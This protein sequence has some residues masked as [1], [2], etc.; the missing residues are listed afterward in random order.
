[1][2]YLLVVSICIAASLWG[3]AVAPIETT[4]KLPLPP[5]GPSTQKTVTIGLIIDNRFPFWPRNEASPPMLEQDADK[6]LIKDFEPRPVTKEIRLPVGEVRSFLADRLKKSKRFSGVINPPL[7]IMGKKISTMLKNCLETSDYLIVGEINAFYTKN[8][9]MNRRANITYPLDATIFSFPSFVAYVMSGGRYFFLTGAAIAV[10]TAECVLS[11]S[12]TIYSVESGQPITTIRLREVARQPVDAY[13]I[14]GEI[15][16]EQDDWI[17]IGRILGEVAL[18]NACV[19][20]IDLIN[21]AI[22]A[23]MAKKK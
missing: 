12:L 18:N 11:L 17:D 8:L 10:H 6:S 15:F 7:T 9:G 2:R 22:Q 3:C 19:R 13:T 1:M 5:P 20:G 23:D 4:E 16:N 21:Q 14:Y